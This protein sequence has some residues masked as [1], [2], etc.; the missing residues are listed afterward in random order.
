MSR[1]V[2]SAH[3]VRISVSQ[4]GCFIITG[5]PRSQL[6]GVCITVSRSVSSAHGVRISVSRFT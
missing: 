6:S 5:T 3:G 2:S 4:C 1:S